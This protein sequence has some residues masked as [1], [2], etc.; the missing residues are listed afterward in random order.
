MQTQDFE[1]HLSESADANLAS[2]QAAGPPRW[3]DTAEIIQ[4]PRLQP[5]L[6]GLGSVD[7]ATS[8]PSTFISIGDLFAVLVSDLAVRLS[9]D[10]DL[11]RVVVPAIWEG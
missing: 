4:F 2:T 5:P 11:P 7:G 8:S 3:A 6:E 1:N 9:G 10:F